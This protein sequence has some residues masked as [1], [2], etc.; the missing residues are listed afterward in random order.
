MCISVFMSWRRCLVE[1]TVLV[2]GSGGPGF[3]SWLCQVDVESMGK[4]LCMQFS[5]PHSFVKRVPDYWQYP[6]VTRYFQ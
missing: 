6:R 2:L 5:S 3:E 4:T 1:N